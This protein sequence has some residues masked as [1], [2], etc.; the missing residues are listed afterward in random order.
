MLMVVAAKNSSDKLEEHR[1]DIS[2]GHQHV[3]FEII[4]ISRLALLSFAPAIVGSLLESIYIDSSLNPAIVGS[5]FLSIC[6]ASIYT[7][8]SVYQRKFRSLTSD[9]MDS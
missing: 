3:I 4:W 2:L 5:V 1:R 7:V 8:I 6:T 9:N